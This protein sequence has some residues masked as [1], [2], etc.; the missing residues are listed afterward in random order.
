MHDGILRENPTERLLGRLVRRLSAS[1]VKAV[2]KYLGLDDNTIH[3]I[4]RENRGDDLWKRGFYMLSEAV[5]SL[6]RSLADVRK[7]LLAFNQDEHVLC[8]V[9]LV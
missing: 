5:T 7:A 6:G 4:E 3:L 9:S 8:R 1:M 2:A